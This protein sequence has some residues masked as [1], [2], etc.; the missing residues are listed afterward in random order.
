MS[1]S[2]PNVESSSNDGPEKMRDGNDSN[3]FQPLGK[4]IKNIYKKSR[5]F[6]DMWAC[7]FPWAELVVSGRWFDLSSQM[8]SL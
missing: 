5:V 6:Q 2:M 7:Q 8:Y 3:Y 4:K 1:I